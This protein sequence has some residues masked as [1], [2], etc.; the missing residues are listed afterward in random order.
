M[1]DCNCW[2]CVEGRALFVPG[3]GK[4]WAERSGSWWW[5]GCA[6]LVDSTTL[7]VAIEDAF[8]TSPVRE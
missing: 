8:P 4:Y 1:A 2:L 7:E 5:E 3:N 6:K